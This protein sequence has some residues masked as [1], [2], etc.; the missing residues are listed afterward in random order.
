LGV[1]LFGVVLSIYYYFGW[2]R[3]AVFRYWKT[4]DD[5]AEDKQP[6]R[7]RREV[8]PVGRWIL[9]GLAAATVVLG[10]FQGPLSTWLERL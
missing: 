6:S 2:I 10:F 9:G 5:E 1:A 3:S 7:E 8:T 4:A